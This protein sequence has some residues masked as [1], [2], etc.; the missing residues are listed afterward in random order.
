V[1]WFAPPPPNASGDQEPT[2]LHA[3]DVSYFDLALHASFNFVSGALVRLREVDVGG[4]KHLRLGYIDQKLDT[5]EIRVRA[6]DNASRTMTLWPW[7]VRKLTLRDRAGYR[8][9]VLQVKQ[10]ADWTHVS[11]KPIPAAV[12]SQP[13][14][15]KTIASS[16]GPAGGV[17]NSTAIYNYDHRSGASGSET[18]QISI[19]SVCSA[20]LM[21]CMT[22]DETEHEEGVT[23]DADEEYDDEDDGAA[24]VQPN[25]CPLVLCLALSRLTFIINTPF[26]FEPIFN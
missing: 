6:F 24:F 18:S 23:M 4:T 25:S 11:D 1:Q 19:G 15:A 26:V 21:Q 3:D 12:T 7:H 14:P 8:R 17:S 20:E 16:S 10:D 2:R 13:A 5:G 22:D 9:R